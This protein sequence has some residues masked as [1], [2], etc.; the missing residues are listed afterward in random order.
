VSPAA[1]EPPGEPADEPYGFPEVTRALRAF[2]SRR[3]LPGSDHDRFF[4]PLV[5]ALRAARETHATGAAWRTVNAVDVPRVEAAVRAALAV[6]AAERAAGSPPDARALEAEL[7]ELCEPLFAALGA[8]A[9]RADLVRAS[10]DAAR[11]AAWRAWAAGMASAFA[12]A[13]RA[14]IAALPAL[15]D[16]RGGRGRLWRRVLRGRGGDPRGRMP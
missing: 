16:A 1:A 3:G 6:L 9:E 8:L 15:A 5:E 7:E 13:D 11:P 10:D 4:A 2:G 14:W 12:A